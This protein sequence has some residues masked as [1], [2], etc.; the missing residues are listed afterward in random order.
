MRNKLKIYISI[1]FCFFF[2]SKNVNAD[3]P[4]IFNITEIKILEN[5]NQING[6]KGGKATSKDGS[7]I[8]AKKFFYNKLTNILEVSGDVRYLDIS[9]NIVITSD[10]AIYFKNDEKVFT[11]GNSKAINENNTITASSLEYDKINNIFKAKK[12]AVA[13]D[14]EKDTTI[15]ADEITYFKNDEKVFTTGN[16]KAINENNTITASSLEYDKINN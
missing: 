4:F 2:I 8:T 6:Y 15:Y 5:G 9:N 14:F 1:L 12:N 11:T 16:S 10:R 13:N 7:T 3:E